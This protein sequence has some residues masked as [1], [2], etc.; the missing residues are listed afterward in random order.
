MAKKLHPGGFRLT[1][2]TAE[3]L[4]VQEI[5]RISHQGHSEMVRVGDTVTR[6]PVSFSDTGDKQSGPLKGKVV[7]VHPKGRFHVVEFGSGVREGFPGAAR[8]L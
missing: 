8:S 2:A 6:C 3:K 7:Y 1:L 5:A 4:A